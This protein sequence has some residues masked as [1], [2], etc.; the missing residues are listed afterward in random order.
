MAHSCPTCNADCDCL[1]GDISEEHCV[2]C[3]D[4]VYDEEDEDVLDDEHDDD[5]E[6][7]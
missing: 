2:C 4:I 7:L 6:F 3:E 1:S 5:D